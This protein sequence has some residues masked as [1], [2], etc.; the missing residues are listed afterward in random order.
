MK[1]TFSD[2]EDHCLDWLSDYSVQ[3]TLLY[4]VPLS[5][6]FVTWVSKTILRILTRLE[7]Y[8]SKPEE[9][10]AS[11][12]NMFIMA[13]INSG[14]T[15]QLVYFQWAP[16]DVPLLLGEYEQFTLEWYQEIG[17]T[18]VITI[19]LMVFS[20]HLANLAFQLLY[21]IKRCW[22]RSCTCNEKRTR[23]LV[24]EDYEKVNIGSEFMLEFRYA[25]MLTV[26]SVTFLY[27]GGMPLLYPV[28]ACFFFLTYWTDKCLL[29]KCHRRPIQFD[30][31]LALNTLTIFKYIF[32]LH[33]AGFLLMFGRTPIF[34]N[35]LWRADD[36][37]TIYFR[38]KEGEFTLFSFYFWL[39]MLILGVFLLWACP[40]K[41]CIRCVKHCCWSKF[42]EKV[43]R[44]SYD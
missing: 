25:N 19:V 32:M 13:F 30:S 22:D 11:A 40:V 5:I 44:M 16:V 24:Q 3:K 31:Y 33:I 34:N 23:K 27:S 18:I 6:V 1:E 39:I 42:Q 29:L 37:T 41:N 4:A 21:A 10:Y 28:A 35:K 8:Q 20:P 7:G 17:S 26:L 12:V 9:I 36:Y 2:G 14:L 38:N 15:L 43:L